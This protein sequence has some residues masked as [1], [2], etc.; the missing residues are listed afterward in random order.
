MLAEA[1]GAELTIVGHD[2][3]LGVDMEALA[4]ALE[5][6]ADLVALTLCSNVSG[7]WLDSERAAALAHAAGAI[8]FLDAAQAAAHRPLC[9]ALTGATVPAGGLHIAADA[10]AF[11]GHK[12]YGPDGSGALWVRRD[13]LEDLVPVSFGGEMVRAVGDTLDFHAPPRCFEAGTP[14]CSA[15]LGLAEAAKWLGK[16]PRDLYIAHE[17]ALG[18]VLYDGLAAIP[19]VKIYSQPGPVISFAL[20]GW[21]AHDLALFLDEEGL[22]LRAGLL[23]AEPFVRALG[24]SALV[25]ASLAAYTSEDDCARLVRAIERA[26]DHN[27]IA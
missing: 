12:M 3:A 19:G 18:R 5:R 27:E 21:H 15:V 14:N 16:G 7:A 6:P 24:E 20:R 9:L 1:S 22:C 23:C 13:I 17:E 11:S 4:R 2:P 26:G 25:R 8:L 10:L